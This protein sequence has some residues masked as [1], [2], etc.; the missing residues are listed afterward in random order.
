MFIQNLMS[1]ALP[2]PELIGVTKKLGRSLAMPTLSIPPPKK[3]SYIPTIQIIYPCAL[4][5]PRFSIA[6]LNGG[7]EPPILGKGRPYGVEDGT[8]RKSVGEFL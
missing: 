1:V 4:V 8:V 7:C 2:V 3:K 5:Y 6:V